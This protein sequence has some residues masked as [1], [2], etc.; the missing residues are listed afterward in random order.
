L[1]IQRGLWDEA[2]VFTGGEYFLGGLKAPVLETIPSEEYNLVKDKLQL[3]Y[4]H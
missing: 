1:F 3:F 2:R 4:N